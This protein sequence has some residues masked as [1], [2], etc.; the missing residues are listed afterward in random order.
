MKVPVTESEMQTLPVGDVAVA[1]QCQN[2]VQISCNG[3]CN[4]DSSISVSDICFRR[5]ATESNK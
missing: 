2:D 3:T 4:I 1:G 5:K